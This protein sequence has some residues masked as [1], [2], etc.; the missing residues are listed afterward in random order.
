MKTLFFSNNPINNKLSQVSF[1]QYDNYVSPRVGKH[2]GRLLTLDAQAMGRTVM[3]LVGETQQDGG[4]QNMNNSPLKQLQNGTKSTIKINTINYTAQHLKTSL[5]S[6]KVF[7]DQNIS[8]SDIKDSIEV[9]EA[10]SQPAQ[11]KAKLT[12]IAG[13]RVITAKCHIFND[14]RFKVQNK[15]TEVTVLDVSAPDLTNY[16]NKAK[17]T[18]YNGLNTQAYKTEMLARLELVL[19]AADVNGCQTIILPSIGAGAFAGGHRQEVVTAIAECF[20]EIL[21]KIQFTNLENVTFSASGNNFNDYQ[22][23]FQNY[24]GQTSVML[25]E[26]EM[27]N[28]AIKLS[29]QK[30]DVG[31]VIAGHPIRPIG[32][33]WVVDGSGHGAQAQEETCTKH[34]VD[35]I[36]AFDKNWNTNVLDQNKWIAVNSHSHSISTPQSFTHAPTIVAKDISGLAEDNFNLSKAIK[37]FCDIDVSSNN[38][39]TTSWGVKLKLG[40]DKQD[41]IKLSRALRDD[42]N[43]EGTTRWGTKRI[44]ADKED[45]QYFLG[46]V[47]SN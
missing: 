6:V 45:R 1:N 23:V 16:Q 21:E 8:Y 29:E 2:T 41:A 31:Y 19:K 46:L 14:N 5:D 33:G 10:N 12:E 36:A 25:T 20:K 35:F 17:Y 47:L 42:L 40:Y 38:I 44:Q 30:I 39:E 37:K 32:N 3:G 4:F 18:S 26:A 43:I 15:L 11:S 13:N 22:Q 24:Q 28:V 7:Y 27:T 9:R 34:F